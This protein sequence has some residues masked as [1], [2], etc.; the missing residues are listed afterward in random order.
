MPF[1]AEEVDLKALR[2]FQ[3]Q[4]YRWS[5]VLFAIGGHGPRVTYV[6]VSAE[7]VYVRAGWIFRMDI[8]RSSLRRAFRR[9]NPWWNMGGTQTNMLGCWAVSGSYRN[10]VALDLDPK[11]RGRLFSLFPISAC[12]LFLSLE[13]PDGFL[14]AIQQ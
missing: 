12:R 14:A 1:M 5:R 9:S 11:A 6:D 3:V 13:D 8:P 4:Y 2:R 10:I 7:T